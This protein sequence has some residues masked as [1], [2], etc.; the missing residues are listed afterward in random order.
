MKDKDKYYQPDISEF[1]VGFEYEYKGDV[2]NEWALQIFNRG[3][4][5]AENPTI[6]QTRVKYLDQEDIESLGFKFKGKALR[7]FFEMECQFDLPDTNS[8]WCKTLK[9]QLDEEHRTLKI[10][11]YIASACEEETLFSGK[12][13]NKSELKRIL[14]MI[15]YEK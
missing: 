6:E 1:H 12:C 9:I 5:F 7:S 2:D 4:G 15:G 3:I 10:E 14:K 13:K 8:F 11:G